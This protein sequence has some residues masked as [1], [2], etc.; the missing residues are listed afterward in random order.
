MKLEEAVRVARDQRRS[1]VLRSLMAQ[2]CDG[3]CGPLAMLEAVCVALDVDRPGP[4]G[5]RYRYPVPGAFH[6]RCADAAREAF[7]LEVESLRWCPER[8]AR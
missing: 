2:T 1:G 8:P 7:S 5:P 3:C 6:S 4:W